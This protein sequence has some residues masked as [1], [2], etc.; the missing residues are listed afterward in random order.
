MSLDPDRLSA[1]L[2]AI[3][4]GA[5]HGLVHLSALVLAGQ[6]VDRQ[7]LIRAAANSLCAVVGGMLVAYFLFPALAGL[8]PW[9]S[10]R[11]PHGLGFVIGAFGWVVA[12]EAYKF[13]KS[14]GA[15]Q[16]REKAE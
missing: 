6:P 5:F 12:P 15:K 4:G 2:S 8:I 7:D 16:T 11:D 13:A 1:A 9:P 14:W 3:A 10:L